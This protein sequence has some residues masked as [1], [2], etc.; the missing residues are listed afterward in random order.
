MNKKRIVITGVGPILPAGIGKNAL[1]NG[2][3]EKRTGLQCVRCCLDKKKWIEFYLHKVE[4]FDLK[5]FNINP[6]DLNY[7][8]TWKGQKE[9]SDLNFI[10][11]AIKLALDDSRINYENATGSI[12]LVISHENPTLEQLLE[13][14]FNESYKLNRGK[15]KLTKK[16]FFNK[17]FLKTVKT[18]YETQSFM[19]LFH[20]ARIFKI[21]RY[22]LCINNACAS[23]LYAL[24]AASDMIKLGKVS[25]VIVAGGD[26]PG[27]F[28]HLWFK[29]IGMYEEDGRTKPFSKKAKGFVMG[30]GATALILEDFE[31]AKKR[32]A[33]IYAEYLGG[34]FRLEG[35]KVTLPAITENYLID[36]INDSFRESHLRRDDIDLICTHGAG[37]ITSD[38]YEA[39]AIERVFGK[40]SKI[41]VTALKP[42]VGHNLGGC[43]LI[44]L[45]ILLISM[46]NNY[47]PPILNLDE[48][49]NKYNLNLVMR[50]EKTK[51]DTILKICCAFA[52]YNAA[53]VFK[54]I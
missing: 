37:T 29:T 51:F 27:V 10:L 19:L 46:Q 16:G 15:L 7:I 28:K 24:E 31:S 2:I 35:W 45:A 47:I 39:R 43:T 34:G 1:L 14:V 12:G 36:S 9:N 44:E 25:K 26:C 21:H 20:S 40:S 53:A 33:H 17:L 3:I 32:G 18:A 30:E 8:F 23:G 4:N 50:E 5:S 49:D 11:A 6:A 48:S 54:R 13:E 22:S 38:Y 52:G 41:P 42:Y